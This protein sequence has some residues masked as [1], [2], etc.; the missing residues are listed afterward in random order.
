MR[1]SWPV[2]SG[3]GGPGSAA[4][5]KGFPRSAC[6]S[7]GEDSLENLIRK[8]RES[9]RFCKNGIKFIQIHQLFIFYLHVLSNK[10]TYTCIPQSL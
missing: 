6:R 8:E 9:H 5:E 3:P 7:P 4:C 10:Y 2:G 1:T